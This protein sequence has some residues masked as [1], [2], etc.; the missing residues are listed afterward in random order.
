MASIGIMCENEEVLV[1]T[2]E[3]CIL[4]HSVT[5]S[6]MGEGT[7]CHLR[8]DLVLQILEHFSGYVSWSVSDQ[9]VLVTSCVPKCQ[10]AHSSI[11]C[12]LF[13]YLGCL[14]LCKNYHKNCTCLAD[15]R[16]KTAINQMVV[17]L[18]VR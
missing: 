9:V 8:H 4:N 3:G 7:V 16:F 18:F 1:K 2:G 17:S 15:F 6:S 13:R 12:G 11:L 10:S 14:I 5:F